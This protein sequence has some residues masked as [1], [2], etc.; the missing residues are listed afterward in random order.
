M[1][2]WAKGAAL[3]CICPGARPHGGMGCGPVAQMVACIGLVLCVQGLSQP[4][5]LLWWTLWR[6][7]SLRKV[8]ELG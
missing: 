3:C 7:R 4:Q 5:T 2:I 8:C 1:L 6:R